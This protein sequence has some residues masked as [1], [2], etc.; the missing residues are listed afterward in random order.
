MNR[1]ALQKAVFLLGALAFAGLHFQS[2]LTPPLSRSEPVEPDDAYSYI[3]KAEQLRADFFQTGPAWRDLRRQIDQPAPT[4]ASAYWHS[5]LE[6]RLLLVYHPAHSILLAALRSAGMTWPKAYAAAQLLGCAI[7]CLGVAAWLYMIWGPGPAGLGLLLLAP[8]YFKG[9]GINQI[10]PSNFAMGIAFATWAMA[11]AS[12]KLADIGTPAGAFA[13]CAM[14][15]A[16]RL[17]SLCAAGFYA[18]RHGLT[19]WRRRIILFLTL[20]PPLIF[21]LLPFLGANLRFSLQAA[22]GPPGF[23]WSDGVL[24]NAQELWGC[25][26]AFINPDGGAA[27]IAAAI[28]IALGF[29]ALAPERRRA[30]T[31]S[32]AAM[33]GLTLASVLYVLPFYP[34]AASQR[35]LIPFAIFLYGAM[36]QA[37]WTTAAAIGLSARKYYQPSPEASAEAPSPQTPPVSLI[38]P[39]LPIPPFSPAALRVLLRRPWLMGLAAA[40]ILAYGGWSEG[41]WLNANWRA[42]SAGVKRNL[43]RLDQ[44][45]VN[46]MLAQSSPE[47]GALYFDEVP[48]YFY[49]SN[50]AWKR[51]AVSYSAV[52]QTPAEL[53]ALRD[54][55]SLRFAVFIHPRYRLPQA[56]ED[57]IFLPKGGGLEI[58]CKTARRLG[59]FQFLFRSES[60]D[61]EVKI[62]VDDDRTGKQTIETWRVWPADFGDWDWRSM[63]Q[64]NK[65]MRT[66]RIVIAAQDD[67]PGIVLQGLR[68]SAS[69]ELDW[70]WDEGITLQALSD[71]L[72]KPVAAFGCDELRQMTGRSVRVIHDKGATVL[73][74]IK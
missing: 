62:I 65:E 57:G 23:R 64:K 60:R 32:G 29:I 70:P 66:R 5:R 43:F 38:L 9:Q 36:G 21:S 54:N 35:F 11:L 4:A 22:T 18:W 39:I 44:S 71:Q 17:Y 28:L 45:Q 51:R 10:V 12:G 72:Q 34:G 15:P 69:S 37:A 63:E 58:L 52:R 49:L 16:G 13:M 41:R 46:L 7:L 33:G 6:Q 2:A 68:A 55:P 73:V 40:L 74:E 50:G 8:V 48:L 24:A 3:L 31:L 59:D 1:L 25:V 14:H 30:A 61:N 42:L 47:E 19:G 67:S 20:L 27:W 53:P 56:T 26:R